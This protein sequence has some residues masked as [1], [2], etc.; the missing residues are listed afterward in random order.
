VREDMEKGFDRKA[1]IVAKKLFNDKSV[2]PLVRL[3]FLAELLDR[4]YGKADQHIDHTSGGL[5]I[6]QESVYNIQTSA[7]Q[8]KIEKANTG[9]DTI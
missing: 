3:K 2:S 1:Y 9:A 6:K 7:Q 4:G 8:E 5:P